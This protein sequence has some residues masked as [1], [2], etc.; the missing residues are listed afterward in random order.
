SLC[1]R[2]DE[3]GSYLFAVK[4]EARSRGGSRSLHD[5]VCIGAELSIGAPRNLFRLTDDASEHVL[6]AAGIGITPLLS[7]AYALEQ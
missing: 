1:G 3:R 5:D 4:K 6:I 7:M 2:P